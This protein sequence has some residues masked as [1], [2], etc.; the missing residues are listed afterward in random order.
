VIKVTHSVRPVVEGILIVKNFGIL[1]QHYAAS[2]SGKLR[3]W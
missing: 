2:Q 1:P 3:H